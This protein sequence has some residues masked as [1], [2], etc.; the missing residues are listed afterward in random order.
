LEVGLGN[1]TSSTDPF[2]AAGS[3]LERVTGFTPSRVQAELNWYS[4]ERGYPL[5]Y[6][7]GNHLVWKLKEDVTRHLGTR[8]AATVDQQFHQ[9]FLQAGNMPVSFMR[10]L[11]RKQ[12]LLES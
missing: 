6:L 4:Q 12:N 8:D 5:S 11:F 2:I 3:L 1:D 7:T 10:E 9:A